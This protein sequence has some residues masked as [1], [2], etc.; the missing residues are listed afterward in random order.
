MKINPGF[1]KKGLNSVGFLLAICRHRFMEDIM[2]ENTKA[3]FK[4]V[5]LLGAGYDTSYRRNQSFLGEVRF[6]EIDHPN[7]QKRKIKIL[8][9]KS[10]EILEKVVYVGL[11]LE[12]DDLDSALVGRDLVDSEPV[13]VIAEGVLS[14]LPGDTFDK[15]LQWVADLADHV[16]FVADYRLQQMTDKD[17]PL[18]VKRWRKEFGFMHENYNSFFSYE[19]MEKKLINFGFRIKRHLHLANLWKEYTGDRVPGHLM[20]T[21]GV[22]IAEHGKGMRRTDH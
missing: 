17:A 2:L 12:K 1:W 22:F 21:A 13:L 15:V 6:I 16:C 10:P 5:V 14:Y 11:D 7:T 20:H 9:K 8:V 18:T 19:T 3:G 4:Q